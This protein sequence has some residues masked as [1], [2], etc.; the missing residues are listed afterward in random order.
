MRG[1]QLFPTP[2]LPERTSRAVSVLSS[3]R[4]TSDAAQADNNGLFPLQNK[5]DRLTL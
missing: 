1:K 2:Y 3:V 4:S 5:R